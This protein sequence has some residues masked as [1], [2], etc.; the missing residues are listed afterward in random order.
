VVSALLYLRQV[1]LPN[2]TMVIIELIHAGRN[3]VFLRDRADLLKMRLLAVRSKQCATKKNKYYCPEIFLD[4][5]SDKLTSTA[6]LFLNV[7]LLS[8]FYYNFP[9]ELDMRLGRHLSDDEVERFAREDPR[10][11]RHLDII[12]KKELL[13]LALQKIE[14][15]RQ[16]DGRSMHRGQERPLQHEKRGRGGWNLF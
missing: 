11:R 16:I 5:V 1:R 7:E 2:S 15:I 10:I 4:V 12:Q 3:S 9:R 6:V 13:E 8:E 14:S